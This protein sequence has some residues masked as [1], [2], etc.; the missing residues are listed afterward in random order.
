MYTYV[1]H[2]M[3][4]GPRQPASWQHQAAE[5]GQ[6]ARW[7]TAQETVRGW[8]GALLIVALLDQGRDVGG[9][10]ILLGPDGG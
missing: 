5:G 3:W 10:G 1:V 2:S 9:L 7:G 8:Q 4:A 6:T